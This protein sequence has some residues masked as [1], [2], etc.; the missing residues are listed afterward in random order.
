MFAIKAIKVYKQMR[1]QKA[2]GGERV[3]LMEQS[4]LGQYCSQYRLS[5]Y[6]SR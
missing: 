5:K 3:N 4:D 6:I 2:N 1:E